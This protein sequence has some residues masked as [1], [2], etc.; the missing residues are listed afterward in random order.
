VRYIDWL[1][2]AVSIDWL[3]CAVYIDW[4]T[5]AEHIISPVENIIHCI[6]LY[7]DYAMLES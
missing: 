5:K 4:L 7:V 2:C 3:T 1:T 6:N